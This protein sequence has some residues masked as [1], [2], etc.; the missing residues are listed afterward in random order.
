MILSVGNHACSQKG[1]SVPLVRPAWPYPCFAVVSPSA[2]NRIG[3]YV[4]AGCGATKE[5][6]AVEIGLIG[7]TSAESSALARQIHSIE[8]NGQPA[9]SSIEAFRFTRGKH[10]H[11]PR[12]VAP[13]AALPPLA[14]YRQNP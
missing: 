10:I 1:N 13:R 7:V 6:L 3:E 5:L 4:C 8:V 2:E 14:G 11:A 9:V 12:N